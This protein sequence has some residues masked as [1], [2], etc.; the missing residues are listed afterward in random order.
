MINFNE[1]LKQIRISS[2]MTQREVVELLQTSHNC[3]ASWEQGRTEPNTDMLRR[4]CK[5]FDVSAD[6]LLGLTDY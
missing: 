2:N 3:Y 6:Y 1:R 5:I 4:L